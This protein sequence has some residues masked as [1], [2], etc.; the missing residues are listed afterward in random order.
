MLTPQRQE[1]QDELFTDGTRA[2]T[3]RRHRWTPLFP[4][5]RWT[6][7]VSYEQAVLA[8]VT[9]VI[10]G[11]VLFSLG[12]ERG[13]RVAGLSPL[14]ARPAASSARGVAFAE[15]GAPGAARITV[16]M[17]PALPA[18]V[19]AARPATTT[20]AASATATTSRSVMPAATAA[21]AT[22]RQGAYTI[23]LAT[24]SQPSLAEEELRL[25]RRRGYQPFVLKTRQY[26]AVCVGAYATR[27]DAARQLATLKSSYRDSFVRQR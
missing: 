10:G 11:L 1:L 20:V 9:L 15:N 22:A 5:T 2:A 23:Q 25:L 13:K 18:V 21:P 26:T 24:F 14:S 16:S 19:V 7:S 8:T 12:M 3:R 6:I 4:L 27:Q 17:T